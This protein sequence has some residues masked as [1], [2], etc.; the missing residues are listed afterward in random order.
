MSGEQIRTNTAVP[1]PFSLRLRSLKSSRQTLA[2]IVREHARGNLDRDT[3]KDLVYG[4]SHLLSYM[5]TEKELDVEA[6][7]EAIEDRLSG[8]GK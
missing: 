1:A 2:R 7:L 4:M 5:K 6:R 3:F 8:E